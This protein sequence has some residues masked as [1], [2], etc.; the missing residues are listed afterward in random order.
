MTYNASKPI[1]I[2]ALLLR[3]TPTRI[4]GRILLLQLGH[5]EKWQEQHVNNGHGGS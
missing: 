4:L 2:I 5:M 1:W 3:S